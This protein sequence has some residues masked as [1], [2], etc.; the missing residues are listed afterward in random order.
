MQQQRQKISQKMDTWQ[1]KGGLQ[2]SPVSGGVSNPSRKSFARSRVSSN[3][4]LAVFVASAGRKQ[5]TTHNP[6]ATSI[7]KEKGSTTNQYHDTKP[8]KKEKGSQ[9]QQRMSKSKPHRPH[10]L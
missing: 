3:A 1:R 2:G 4:D 8:R 5:D 6:L 9:K 7:H 10:C